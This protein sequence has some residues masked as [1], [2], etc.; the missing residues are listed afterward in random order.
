VTLLDRFIGST[1]KGLLIIFG[2]ITAVAILGVFDVELMN[3]LLFRGLL[4]FTPTTEPIVRHWGLMIFGVGALMIV[5][6]FWPWLQF[7]TMFFAT[8]EKIFIVWLALSV[9][10]QSWGSAYLTSGIIDGIIALYGI[11]YFISSHG[12]PGRWVRAGVR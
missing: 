11:L 2:L 12:R 5:S 3:N 6:A 10:D 8:V 9:R 4:E 1:L 7:T